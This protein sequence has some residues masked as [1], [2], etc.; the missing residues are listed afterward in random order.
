MLTAK[1]ITLPN[2]KEFIPETFDDA[3]GDTNRVWY[4]GNCE[5]YGDFIYLKDSSETTGGRTTGITLR[6]GKKV[7]GV[8]KSNAIALFKDTGIDYRAAN[9]ISYVIQT[10]NEVLAQEETVGGEFA[11]QEY[12]QHLANK[13]GT[14]VNVIIRS[15]TGATSKYCSPD[16]NCVKM[17]ISYETIPYDIV[18]GVWYTSKENAEKYRSIQSKYLNVQDFS[19]EEYDLSVNIDCLLKYI[20]C[21]QNDIFDNVG[22]MDY[23]LITGLVL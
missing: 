5:N 4:I 13:M 23:F 1:D 12:A 20:K 3:R 11:I 15:L 7:D 21:E 14:D 9:L 16:K 19:P 8:S 2:S 6:N 10:E 22:N 18:F 17:L